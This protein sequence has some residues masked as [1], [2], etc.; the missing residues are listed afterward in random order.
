ME[1]VCFTVKK[2][3]LFCVKRAFS[4]YSVFGKIR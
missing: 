4:E 2:Q 3:A 1:S